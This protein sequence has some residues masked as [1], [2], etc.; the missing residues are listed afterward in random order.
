MNMRYRG[1]SFSPDALGQVALFASNENFRS[2]NVSELLTNDCYFRRPVRPEDLA[3]IDFSRPLDRDSALDLGG[4]I[5]HRLLLNCFECRIH[6]PP[7]SNAPE[8]L[9]SMQGFYAAETTQAARAAQPFLEEFLFAGLA[10]PEA[11]GRDVSIRAATELIRQFWDDSGQRQKSLASA[12]ERSPT[13][14]EDEAFILIQHAGLLPSKQW[15]VRRARGIGLPTDT[16]PE[17]ALCAPCEP[18]LQTA[19]AEAASRRRLR[20]DPHRYWQFYLSTALGCTNFLYSRCWQAGRAYAA[21]AAVVACSVHLH[22]FQEAFRTGMLAPAADSLQPLDV[23]A[24]CHAV[25]RTLEHA[26]ATYGSGVSVEFAAELSAAARQWALLD[27]D[28]AL[29]IDWLGNLERSRQTARRLMQKVEQDRQSIRLDTFVETLDMC[30]T[31][32]VHNEH[33]LVVVES[34]QM[35]F[36][37]NVGMQL[38]L[39]EGDMILVPRS[40]LHGSSITTD[41]C[42]YHQPVIPP[43]WLTH[44]SMGG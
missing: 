42:V 25:G 41:T 31:T 26:S 35:V 10:D 1:G 17:P 37:A 8:H 15:A 14:T 33:R 2:A 27:A 30:S 22:A 44:A 23:D 19:L 16:W 18:R 39:P 32:H 12:V 24:L 20:L 4:L 5:G 38:H 9:R 43:D 3:L 6:R 7:S 21:L 11:A 40:R 36:W 28:L 29:Q 34:G 13:R